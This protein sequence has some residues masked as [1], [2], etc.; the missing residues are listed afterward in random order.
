M[1]TEQYLWDIW[2]TKAITSILRTMAWFCKPRS[3]IQS[4]S[5]A[6]GKARASIAGLK[7]GSLQNYYLRKGFAVKKRTSDLASIVACLNGAINGLC[8]IQDPEFAG[9]SERGTLQT[10]K[11]R[12]EAAT[13]L[14]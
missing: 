4:A 2:K 8:H 5:M 9:I 10:K 6:T 11:A 1:S 3:L 13:I 14:L 7:L 12:Q